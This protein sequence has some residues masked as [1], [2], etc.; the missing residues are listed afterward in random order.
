MLLRA[1]REIE[2][3][4]KQKLVRKGRW[5]DM[6]LSV[7][8]ETI[9]APELQCRTRECISAVCAGAAGEIAR[10]CASHIESRQRRN[11]LSKT[12]DWS[13]LPYD[14]QVGVRQWASLQ[15]GK[16]RPNKGEPDR[17][18]QLCGAKQREG[19]GLG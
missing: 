18:R 17:S 16:L 5:L 9:D 6:I 19:N 7:R 11:S 13:T 14:L 10:T 8:S 2:T 12:P 3:K 4:M 15:A 1:L